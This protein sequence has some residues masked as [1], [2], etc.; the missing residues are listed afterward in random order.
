MDQKISI[1]IAERTFNL[2]A[3]SPEQEEVIR[4]AAEAI[5]RRLEMYTRKNPGKAL[6]EL[7]AMVALNESFRKIT[8]QREIESRDAEVQALSSELANYLKDNVK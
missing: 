7:L 6:V 1:K 3:S 2:S 4:L 8:L 5:N